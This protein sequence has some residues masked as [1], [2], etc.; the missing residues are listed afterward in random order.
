MSTTNIDGPYMVYGNTGALPTTVGGGTPDPNP[1]AGPSAFFQGAAWMD[2][3]VFFP[4]D[5]TTG[6]AGVVMGHLPMPFMKSVSQIP[7]A[8]AANNICAAQATTANT[9]MTLATASVGVERNIPIVPYSQVLNGATVTTAAIALDYGFGFANVT[10]GNTT[11]TVSSSALFREGMPLVIARV[12]NSGGTAPLLTLVSSIASATTLVIAN[13]PL[14]TSSTAAIGTGNLWGSP[15]TTYDTPTAAFPFLSRGPALV[16]DPRQAISRGLR[17]TGAG[18]STGGTFLVAGWDIYCQPMT[19]LVTVAA[20]STGYTFKTFKYIASVTPTFTDAATYTVGTTDLFGFN[21]R[22]T[23][24][25]ETAVFWNGAAQT[26]VTGWV[27]AD[28]TS[29]ATTT[30]DDV[31]GTIQTS[32]TG[33]GSGIGANASNGTISSLAMSGRRLEIGQH[34]R[35]VDVLDG[36]PE[37]AV[38]LF[39]VT[40]V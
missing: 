4:K 30:T 20:A 24:W 25:E 3:R 17:I 2:P 15:A 27:A 6:G 37:N 33:P 38:A 36:M 21:Y 31:R 28:V 1:D 13:T 8:L 14:A 10:A 35:V 26:S 5:E 11:I 7:A 23:V 18:G 34:L 19:E 32:A 12:G 40:Q 29:P 16:L 22:S 9:A 39:G